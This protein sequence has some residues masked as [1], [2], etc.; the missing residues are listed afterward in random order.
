MVRYP[1]ESKEEGGKEIRN[2][3]VSIYGKR[4]HIDQTLYEYLLE[5]LLIFVS[6]KDADGGGKLAFHTQSPIHYYVE[7][8]NGLRRFIFYEH[9]RKAVRV[10]GDA[11][12]YRQIKSIMRNHIDGD[13][14]EEK[15]AF[16]SSVQDLFRGYSAVLKKRSWCAQSLLPLCPELIFCEQMP[17]DKKRIKKAEAGDGDGIYDEIVTA[18]DSEF[19]IDR[20]N[21]FA[22]GGELYYLHLLQELEK[23]EEAKR[24]LEQKL[25]HLLTAKSHHFSQLASWIQQIWVEDARINP[26]KLQRKM[27]MG[28]IPAG[29]YEEDGR[30]SVQELRCFL[31]NELHPV[32][33][34]EL[35]TQGVMLQVLRM[36]SDR[37]CEYTCRGRIAWIVDMRGSKRDTTIRQLSEQSYHHMNELFVTALNQRITEAKENGKNPDY[38]DFLDGRKETIDLFRARGKDIKLIIPARGA[39]E[40]FSLSEDVARFLVLSLIKPGDKMDLD[41]FLDE[42]YQHY[43]MVIGPTEYLKASAADG[44]PAALADSFNQNRTAFQEFL[45]SIGCLRALSDATSIVINPYQEVVLSEIRC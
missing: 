26:E 7:P 28:Y 33:R 20:H 9:A 24:D 12:A 32:K 8:R 1:I 44:M 36:I 14:E 42:L 41:T 13:S 10:E 34:I 18:Y 38:K 21:F 39:H 19:S 45:K 11:Q 25:T 23:N 30:L 17:E 22:R 29:R 15:E 16:I 35:M 6:A 31:S 37:T 43:H 2:P 40:R 5:F 4:F 3:A 27:T